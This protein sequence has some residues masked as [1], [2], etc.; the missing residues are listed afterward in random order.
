MSPGPPGIAWHGKT[1][2]CCPT[3]LRLADAAEP[4]ASHFEKHQNRGEKDVYILHVN[5]SSISLQG[6][7]P[8]TFVSIP[9]L[10]EIPSSFAI[11]HAQALQSFCVEESTLNLGHR[12]SRLYE[13]GSVWRVALLERNVW[14]AASVKVDLECNSE[15][16]EDL[17]GNVSRKEWHNSRQGKTGDKAIVGAGH[18]LQDKFGSWN[19]R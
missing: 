12:R 15:S 8:K 9:L 7:R 3:F 14:N 13:T 2:E 5:K 4:C 16:K 18:G 19:I 6:I 11:A 10:P 1:N 17:R